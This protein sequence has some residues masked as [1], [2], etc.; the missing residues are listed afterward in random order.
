[1]TL[2]FSMSPPT[3]QDWAG[4]AWALGTTV[5]VGSSPDPSCNKTSLADLMG[6]EM[7]HVLELLKGV[8]VRGSSR[9]CVLCQVL[10][11]RTPAGLEGWD[12]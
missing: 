1:M 3:I 12:S 9:V 4:G 10:L 11:Y 8:M 6:R 7:K 2:A 5:C